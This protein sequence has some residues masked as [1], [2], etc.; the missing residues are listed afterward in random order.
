MHA[1]GANLSSCMACKSGAENVRIGE[2]KKLT[3]G[4]LGSPSKMPGTSYG[5]SALKCITGSKLQK[6]EGSTCHSCYA[7]RGH[8]IY[9]SVKTAHERRLASLAGPHW[10]AGMVLLITHSKTKYHRWLDSG[11]LQSVEMLTKIAAV[12]ALTPKVKHWL[13]TRELQI[14]LA[15]SKQGGIV[16]PNLVIRVS[17][18]MVDG[19][20]TKAW[21]N[22]STVHKDKPTQGYACPASKY[23]N[24]CGPCR[25]CWS[26]D[27]KNT[28]YHIH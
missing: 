14:V 6:V 26:L 22:T 23:G 19:P 21:H 3:G 4:G 7:M 18:T 20:P 12:A 17:A 5:I 8:Y 24:T 13:P 16:P 11:D 25:A 9:S 28:S 2:A 1:R 10:T 15:Y 27:N